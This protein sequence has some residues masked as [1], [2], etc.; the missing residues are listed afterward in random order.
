MCAWLVI[1]DWEEQAA[2][3]GDTQSPLLMMKRTKRMESSF[4]HGMPRVR[5]PFAFPFPFLSGT[6]G[7]LQQRS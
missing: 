6:S 4:I 1:G 2:G 7:K 3:E 5:R